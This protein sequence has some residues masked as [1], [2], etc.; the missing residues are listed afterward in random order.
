M[1]QIRFSLQLSSQHARH[2]AAILED[3][4][5]EDALPVAA[6]EVDEKSGVWSVAVYAPDD[7]AADVQSRMARLIA[8]EKVEG[9][10]ACETLEDTDWISRTL[11]D[12]APVR[13][14]RFIVHGSHDR[15]MPAPHQHAILIDAGLAFGTGHHGTTA[16]CLDM[17]GECLKR[18]HPGNALD[19]GTGSGVLAIAIAKALAIPVL[20]TD[21][22]PVATEVATRNCVLNGVSD[23]VTCLTAPGFHHRV[24]ASRVQFD[25]IVANILAG[26][27]QA[28]ARDLAA[29]A[30][31]GATI[32]LS[33]LLPHQKARI[34]ATY[35]QHGVVLRKAHH[36]DGWLILVLEKS[37]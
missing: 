3:E 8:M 26:P 10:I 35:R 23:R 34:V 18:C 19:L 11:R 27:L 9:S 20:A 12:L 25:L 17:L 37:A 29:H 30:A 32:I 2:I 31:P 14:G 22:D 4:F 13:S 24:F 28:I 7:Q 21:I 15:H 5:E 1:S 16:G 33:G 36:R 6:F